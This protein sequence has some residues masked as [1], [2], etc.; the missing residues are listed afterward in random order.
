METADGKSG[1]A[2]RVMISF[3]DGMRTNF[4]KELALDFESIGNVEIVT[5][6]KRL[7]ER[8]FDNLKAKTE[9]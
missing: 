9:K 5:K 1:N 6:R 3:P 2:Y 4:G 8:L 7:I